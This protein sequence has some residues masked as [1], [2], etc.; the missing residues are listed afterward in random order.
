MSAPKK[1]KPVWAATRASTVINKKLARGAINQLIWHIIVLIKHTYIIY[2]YIGD[3]VHIYGLAR[4][5]IHKIKTN[6]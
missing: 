6:E 5:Q 4:N 1:K 2:V 3:C